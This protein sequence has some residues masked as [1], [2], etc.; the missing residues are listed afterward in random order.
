MF[1]STWKTLLRN[2]MNEQGM[3]LYVRA[4]SVTDKV[5][6]ALN[7]NAIR[8]VLNSSMNIISQLFFKLGKKD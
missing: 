7:L 3:L 4:R 2:R 6:I 1:V 5:T 8:V